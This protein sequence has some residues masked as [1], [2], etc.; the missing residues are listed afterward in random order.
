MRALTQIPGGKLE[1]YHWSSVYRAAMSIPP[2]PKKNWS[3]MP[4]N[5]LLFQGLGLEW[6]MLQRPSPFS[7]QGRCLMHPAATRRISYDPAATAEEGK[8][9]VLSQW[10]TQILDFAQRVAATSPSGAADIRLGLLLWAT[11][12]SEF[13]YFEEQ[14]E[15]PDP[16]D[17]Y[18]EWGD[19]QAR[20]RQTRNLYIFEK[21]TGKKRYSVTQPRNGAKLQPY[22]D[23]PTEEEGAYLFSVEACNLHPLSVRTSSR[24]SVGWKRPITMLLCA[25]C[26]R[27]QAMTRRCSE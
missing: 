23:V 1:E 4:F 26:W 2:D 3:N 19:G 10:A 6:K 13:L 27:I 11:D 9:Q 24:L 18:A 16:D 8:Q 20:G 21:A 7:D 22:Y 25:G 14:L 5:D 17:F 12:L 15:V